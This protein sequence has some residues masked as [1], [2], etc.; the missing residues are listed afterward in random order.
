MAAV[1]NMSDSLLALGRE[2]F[3]RFH[4][5][6][7]LFYLR[8]VLHAADVP[9][10]TAAEANLTMARIEF[11]RNQLALARVRLERA[12]ELAPTNAECH[13][14]LGE[15]LE[16][17]NRGTSAES[18]AHY[19]TAAELAPKDG[20]KRSA[21]ALRVSRTSD[22]AAGLGA[23]R[24]TYQDHGSDPE[25]VG[26]YMEGLIEAQ[27][28]AD[29]E[30]LVAQASYRNEQ[31]GRFRQ[32][33]NRVRFRIRD[34]EL[35]GQERS[36]EANPTFLP[37]RDF[38][39]ET[40]ASASLDPPRPDNA[41]TPRKSRRGQPRKRM[42]RGE[43]S[44]TTRPTMKL[45]PNVTLAQ[46]LRQYGP[47]A[48]GRIHDALG[49]TGKPRAADRAAQIRASLRDPDHLVAVLRRL[50]TASRRLLRSM[51]ASGGCLPL[52]VLKQSAGPEAPPPDYFQPLLDN[53]LLFLGTEAEPSGPAPAAI[54][55]VPADLAERIAK[56]LRIRTV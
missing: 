35:R 8:G 34:K 52:S 1:L 14:L 53:A 15:V 55:V 44:F 47:R 27:R 21:Y 46:A 40:G 31:D 50:P 17:E 23:L 51:V 11:A 18:L 24:R 49:L 6:K 28:F 9:A 43:A 39:T 22:P 20:K 54:A 26:N 30:L 38:S 32:L 2:Q 41:T 13:F 5:D 10:N 37:F 36:G 12:I 45:A 7:A 16:A 3:R 42:K 25:V 56:I 33:R 29:A 19:Q 48:L 4:Y